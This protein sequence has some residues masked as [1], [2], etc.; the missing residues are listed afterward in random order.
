MLGGTPLDPRPALCALLATWLRTPGAGSIIRAR[1]P[2]PVNPSLSVPPIET[3]AYLT[4]EYVL[5]CVPS[6]SRWQLAQGSRA[7][8]TAAPSRHHR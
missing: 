6:S 8:T 4:A 1:Q 2:A 7:R 5:P 3:A